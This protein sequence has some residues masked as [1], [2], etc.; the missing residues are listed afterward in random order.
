VTRDVARPVRRIMVERLVLDGVEVP[1]EGI[2][3]L[4]AGLGDALREL[5]A[6]VPAVPAHVAS[7]RAPAV[8]LA[9]ADPTATGRVLGAAVGRA[10]GG[11]ADGE[12]PVGRVRP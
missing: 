4:V 7:L 3:A 2:D 11:V 5:V 1:P 6:D 10:V 9:P 8:V 12:T